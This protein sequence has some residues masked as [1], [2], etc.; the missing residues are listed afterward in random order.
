MLAHRNYRIATAQGWV[1]TSTYRLPGARYAN[2]LVVA[3]LLVVAAMLSL[4]EDTRV[5]LYIAP[6]WFGLL[7]IGCLRTRARPV[8]EAAL[9]L[10]TGS[11]CQTRQ[12]PDQQQG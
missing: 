10:R 3:F 4:D 1:T 2:W 8:A 9:K 7:G 6:F 11:R 12:R 5:A